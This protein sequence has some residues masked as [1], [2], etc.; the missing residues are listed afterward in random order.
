MARKPVIY[1]CLLGGPYDGLEY[2]LRARKAPPAPVID[3]GHM[4]RLHLY[5]L[6]LDRSVVDGQSLQVATYVH[7]PE[8]VADASGSL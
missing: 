5:R 1:V 3:L 6:D 8:G 2:R 4:S 7:V